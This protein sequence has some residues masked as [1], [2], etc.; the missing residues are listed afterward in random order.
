MTD[1]T[2]IS[3]FKVGDEVTL[4]VKGRI[5]H[6]HTSDDFVILDFG[7]DEDYIAIFNDYLD[8]N[9]MTVKRHLPSLPDIN[10][11]YVPRDNVDDLANSYIYVFFDEN[12]D[13]PWSV[14]GQGTVV[15]GQDA[16][17]DAIQTH[18]SFGGLVPLVA[19]GQTIE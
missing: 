8:S 9:T 1:I 6:A 7:A 19:K 18:E 5:S 2:D 3:Q 10:G 12:E 14:F 13:G 17:V 4:T 15:T 16:E 11:V